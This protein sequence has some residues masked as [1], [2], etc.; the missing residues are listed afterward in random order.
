MNDPGLAIERTELAWRRTA[1]AIALAC[2]VAGRLHV[3]DYGPWSFAIG[4]WVLPAL[5]AGWGWSR[6][7]ETDVSITSSRV[8][9]TAVS[10]T[11]LAVTGLATA[12][13][14]L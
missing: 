7:D 10:I 3:D 12:V 1:L 4:L 14:T 8:A 6:N 5:A 13:A 2:L 9:L 11:G